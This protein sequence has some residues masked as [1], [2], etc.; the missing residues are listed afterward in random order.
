VPAPPDERPLR[1]LSVPVRIAYAGLR[2]GQSRANAAGLI[3]CR[4]PEDPAL[5]GLSPAGEAAVS[6]TFGR[7]DSGATADLG[8]DTLV[9]TSPLSRAQRSAEIAAAALGAAAPNVD[10]RLI[11][12]DFGSF[13]HQPVAAYETVWAADEAGTPPPAGVESVVELAARIA[14]LIAD[15]E[16]AGPTRTVLLVSHGDTLDVAACWF[17]GIDPAEHR[18]HHPFATAEMRR[19]TN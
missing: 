15:L 19:L 16:A 14:S 7:I 5:S 1:L 4:L 12:R 17:A 18:R 6:A 13:E 8:P 11:E 2:H 10:G 3:A 9:V